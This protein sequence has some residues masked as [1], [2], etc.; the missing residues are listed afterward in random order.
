MGDE[1]SPPAPR[2]KEEESG[3]EGEPRSP[4]SAGEKKARETCEM[5]FLRRIDAEGEESESRRRS[6]GDDPPRFGLGDDADLAADLPPR[7][8]LVSLVGLL[9]TMTPSSL[10]ETF[11]DVVAPVER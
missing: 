2:R 11:I 1:G 10:T 6:D 7:F 9:L 3:E 8:G 4:R 5:E